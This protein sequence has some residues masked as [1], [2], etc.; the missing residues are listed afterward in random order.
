MNIVKEEN[1]FNWSV[2]SD[3]RWKENVQRKH[4]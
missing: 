4:M 1:G 3:G 2:L